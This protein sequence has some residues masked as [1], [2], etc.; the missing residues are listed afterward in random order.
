MSNTD[1]TARAEVSSWEKRRAKPD[2]DH[3]A[4][5]EVTVAACVETPDGRALG[6]N[7]VDATI[8]FHA[9]MP[10]PPR[11]LTDAEI[12][13]T[14]THNMS[15]VLAA[16]QSVLASMGFAVLGMID[17]PMGEHSSPTGEFGKATPVTVHLV[18]PD[19]T[20]RPS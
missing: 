11:V 12:N 16:I 20:G 5:I 9:S 19:D 8:V 17:E 4:R 13:R 18:Q 10:R 6:D 1:Y 7:V 14:L 15:P 3:F 2:E